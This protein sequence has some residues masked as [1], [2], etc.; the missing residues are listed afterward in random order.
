MRTSTWP[1]RTV[2]PSLT[3]ISRTIPLPHPTQNRR[4]DNEYRECDTDD[5]E[6]AGRVVHDYF[7][8]DDLRKD[9]RCKRHQLDRKRR[10]Q[11]IAPDR[12]VFEQLGHEPPEAETVPS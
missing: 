12:A 3:R 10:K 9:R 4:K 1:A 7:V 8:Y 5:G 2:S 11:H 6:R